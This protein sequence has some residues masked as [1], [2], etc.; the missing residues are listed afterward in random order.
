MLAEDIK[1]PKPLI[2]V[3]KNVVT[4]TPPFGPPPSAKFPGKE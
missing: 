4:L 3:V 2:E 1:I